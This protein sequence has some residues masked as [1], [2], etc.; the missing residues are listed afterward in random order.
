MLASGLHFE[1]AFTLKIFGAWRA[2]AQRQ[3][4]VRLLV[5]GSSRR[6][7]LRRGWCAARDHAAMSRIARAGG[8]AAAG[9]SDA[10]L[11]RQALRRWHSAALASSTLQGMF[12]ASAS[13]LLRAALRCWVRG[14]TRYMAAD[15]NP[16]PNP[17]P[18]PYPKP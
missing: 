9:Y 12:H 8:L 6:S 7:L 14:G 10:Q 18:N 11:R 17:N 1:G 2:Q 15:P 16:N 4:V 13:A 3:A 5:G